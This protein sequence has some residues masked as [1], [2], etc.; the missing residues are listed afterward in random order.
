MI[1][2]IL[3]SC[4]ELHL[5]PSAPTLLSGST[6]CGGISRVINQ[7]YHWHTTEAATLQWGRISL[8]KICHQSLWGWSR[9]CFSLWR[10]PSAS[11]RL[12]ENRPT[13]SGSVKEGEC[14]MSLFAM[15][16][17]F[18]FFPWNNVEIRW[19]F[20]HENPLTRFNYPGWLRKLAITLEERKG[21]AVV[22]LGIL[23][24]FFILI[25]GHLS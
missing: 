6:N 11:F 24:V 16:P 9:G 3:M 8:W 14:L 10:F 23:S 5:I 12:E 19:C 13:H 4:L 15:L 22:C 7:K 25:Q 17:V 1:R 21:L 18:C 20:N 2:W